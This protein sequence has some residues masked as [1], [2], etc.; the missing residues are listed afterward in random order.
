MKW[1]GDTP[2]A[3]D[4]GASADKRAAA[5]EKNLYFPSAAMMMMEPQV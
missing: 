1:E 5:F 4:T 2:V 3:S